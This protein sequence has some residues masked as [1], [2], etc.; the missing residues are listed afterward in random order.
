M[1]ETNTTATATGKRYFKLATPYRVNVE[2]VQLKKKTIER[3]VLVE[4]GEI[5]GEWETP[6]GTKMFDVRL[7]DRIDRVTVT[8]GVNQERGT[9]FTRKG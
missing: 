3:P 7:F 4:S 5:V 9:V 1:S 8:L 6:T 2:L